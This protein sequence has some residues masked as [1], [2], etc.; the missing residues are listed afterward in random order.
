MPVSYKVK[1][2]VNRLDVRCLGILNCSV[3]KEIKYLVSPL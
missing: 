3:L 2:L 1:E